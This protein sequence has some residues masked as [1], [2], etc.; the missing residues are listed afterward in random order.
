MINLFSL[1]KKDK[2]IEG[3]NL[4][5][6]KTILNDNENIKPTGKYILIKKNKN[7]KIKKAKLNT[8]YL[9]IDCVCKYYTTLNETQVKG[10][11]LTIQRKLGLNNTSNCLTC[12]K[13]AIN[14]FFDGKIL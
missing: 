10:T 7:M 3:I 4:K 11:C 14:V 2:E 1:I 13:N 12:H 8:K 6:L 9:K 5:T